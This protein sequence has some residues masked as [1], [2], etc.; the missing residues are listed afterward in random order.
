[1]KILDEHC[2]SFIR[3]IVKENNVEVKYC[4]THRGHYNEVKFLPIHKKVQETIAGK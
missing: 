3:S 2:P 4:K 1:M